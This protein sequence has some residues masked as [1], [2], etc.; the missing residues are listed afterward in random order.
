MFN[1]GIILKA[2]IDSVVAILLILNTV[3]EDDGSKNLISG[4]FLHELLCRL[5]YNKTIQV[6]AL[7]VSIC[8]ILTLNFERYLAIVHPIFHKAKF[9][10]TRIY[11]VVMFITSVAVGFA[12]Q[13]PYGILTT[14]I[15][16]EGICSPY[17]I[18]MSKSFKES[19]G[20]LAFAFEY[21]FPLGVT[22]CLYLSMAKKLHHKIKPQSSRESSSEDGSDMVRARNN[23]LKTSFLLTVFFILCWS[24][25]QF[26]RILF[27]FDQ[28]SLVSISQ[29]FS[30][31]VFMVHSNCCV[32]PCIYFFKYKP[33]HNCA[34]EF[35]VKFKSILKQ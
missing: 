8:S 26:C 34:K 11:S 22:I 14:K 31:T 19:V 30:F 1:F 29:L 32:N 9:M 7:Y 24:P 2:C 16:K 33:F 13:I 17:S 25:Y 27:Y 35:L 23:V 5:W 20:M 6:V 18:N 21:L 12:Y 4:N 28:V 3:F 10:Q 15:T